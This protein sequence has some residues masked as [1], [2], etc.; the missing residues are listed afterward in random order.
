MCVCLCACACS[1]LVVV[2]RSS[3]VI[4]EG[5]FSTELSSY[6]FFFP[7]GFLPVSNMKMKIVL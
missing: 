5:F 2:G 1:W 7:K 3:G 4:N 6:V